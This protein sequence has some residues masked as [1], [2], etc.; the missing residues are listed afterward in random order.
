MATETGSPAA[1]ARISP[2]LLITGPTAVGKSQIALSIAEAFGGEIVSADSMQV[3]RGLDI[4][5]AK[6][7][8]DEQARVPHHLIDVVDLNQTFDAGKFVPLAR[9][10]VADIQARGHLAVLCGG[11]GLYLKAF[12]EGLGQAPSRDDNLRVKLEHTPMRELLDELAEC[13]PVTYQTI[14]RR[15]SRRVIR[16]LEVIRLTGKPFSTQRAPWSAKPPNRAMAIGL[17]RPRAELHDRIDLR[18]EKMFRDGLVD[19][20]KALLNRGLG[21]NKTAIQALGYHQVLDYLRGERSLADTIELVKIRTRQFAKRQLTWF[22]RQMDLNWIELNGG[23]TT[24]V[25]AIVEDALWKSGFS[26]NRNVV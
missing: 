24:E 25:V 12:F 2:A 5:T 19:E 22:R 20:T 1:L 15:N 13:D 11:S 4:G 14:D 9:K 18:V 26:P 8:L 6:P 23:N 16:A 17:S 3:Y 21:E 10:A 7:G